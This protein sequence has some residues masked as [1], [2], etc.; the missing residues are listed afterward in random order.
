M[1]LAIDRRTLVRTGGVVTGLEALAQRVFL[2]LSRLQ[3]EYFLDLES[4]LPTDVLGSRPLRVDRLRTQIRT[5][6]MDVAGVLE[7]TQIEITEAD[8]HVSV[9]L[10]VRGELGSIGVTV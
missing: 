5:E 1:D 10:R 4:G 6:V 2:R 3:G 7:I 8:R 9:S